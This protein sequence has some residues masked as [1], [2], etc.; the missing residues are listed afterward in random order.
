MRAQLI[1][2]VLAGGALANAT[3]RLDCVAGKTLPGQIF[4]TL[5]LKADAKSISTDY[6]N[7]SGHAVDLQIEAIR[8]D[9]G[10]LEIRGA[11]TMN[12]GLACAGGCPQMTYRLT[13][14]DR[15]STQ[16]NAILTVTV[17]GF[18][19]SLGLAWINVTSSSYLCTSADLGTLGR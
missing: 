11:A 6:V 4:Q 2:L 9:E 18:S 15:P 12:K 19:E 14:G 1:V 13:L 5:N 10:K 7:K 17:E 16:E 3:P 8:P